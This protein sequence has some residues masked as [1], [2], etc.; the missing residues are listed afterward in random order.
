MVLE[1]RSVQADSI[2]DGWTHRV[3]A[4]EK[5]PL[6]SNYIWNLVL[7]SGRP[8]G[9]DNAGLDL[10]QEERPRP[11]RPRPRLPACG[12]LASAW[13]T[14]PDLSSPHLHPGQ[15]TV[16]RPPGRPDLPPSSAR[17]SFLQAVCMRLCTS[18]WA[19][20]LAPGRWLEPWPG[21]SFITR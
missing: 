2:W 18:K 4:R 15:L 19:P 11:R 16:S 1:T 13:L 9:R 8:T 14:I 17:T 3:Q 7:Q 10:L 6:W 20:A 12:Q 5:K 21:F